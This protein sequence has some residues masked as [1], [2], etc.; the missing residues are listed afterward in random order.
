VA[1]RPRRFFGTTLFDFFAIKCSTIKASR[2]EARNTSAP[3][4][5]PEPRRGNPMANKADG[6]LSKAARQAI[7]EQLRAATI[8][9]LLIETNKPLTTASLRSIITRLEKIIAQLAPPES[10]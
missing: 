10:K 7:A 4:L 1:G 8:E 6:V 9:L 5:I 3:A 2:E